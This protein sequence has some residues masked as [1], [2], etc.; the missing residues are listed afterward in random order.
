MYEPYYI[1]NKYFYN[2]L[3]WKLKM[4]LSENRKLNEFR[5]DGAKYYSEKYPQNTK[6]G[7]IVD[8]IDSYGV[9]EFHKFYSIGDIN[10]YF[11]QLERRLN[12]R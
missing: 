5:F 12:I 8:G 9:K 10:F 11:N 7:I 6:I 1:K 3:I 2:D 4:I